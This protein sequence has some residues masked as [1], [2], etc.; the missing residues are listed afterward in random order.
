MLVPR[1]RVKLLVVL[2]KPKLLT[3]TSGPTGNAGDL[4]FRLLLLL[5]LL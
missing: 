3:L 2:I 4:P 5:L 1:P